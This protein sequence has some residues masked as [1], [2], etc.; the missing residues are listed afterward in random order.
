M[1]VTSRSHPIEFALALA[2]ACAGCGT[3]G[4]PLSQCNHGRYYADCAGPDGTDDTRLGCDPAT[5]E[6][7]LFAGGVVASGHVVSDCPLDD[8]CCVPAGTGEW[9][10]VGWSPSGEVLD[11]AQND[12]GLLR[13]GAIGREMPLG[14]PVSLDYEGS[15]PSPATVV[16]EATRGCVVGNLC[17]TRPLHVSR[18]GESLVLEIGDRSGV[19][20]ESSE[21]EVW[22]TA[23]G[24]LRARFFVHTDLRSDAPP[25]ARCARSGRWIEMVGTLR[26]SPNAMD[27]PE[28][29]HG[30]FDADLVAPEGVL[31]HYRF[32]F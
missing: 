17:G 13:E 16:I 7:R 3:D 27:A 5:G 15:G 18:S 4:P 21:I 26:L 31:G 9:P 23:P 8:L 1:Q 11:Q 25:T 24:E 28:L 19:S 29:A 32:A 10:F 2:A 30:L 20:S 14:I 6:C 12:I 22:P